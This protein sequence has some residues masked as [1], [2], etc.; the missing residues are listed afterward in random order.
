MLSYVLAALTGLC[1]LGL[2]VQAL[3]AEAGLQFQAELPD[4]AEAGMEYALNRRT[5]Q[6]YRGRGTLVLENHGAVSA[7]VY[8]NGHRVPLGDA[9]TAGGRVRLDVGAWC[10]DGANALKVLRIRPLGARLTVG[11]LYPELIR[12]TPEQAGFSSAGLKKV[13]EVIERDVQKGFPGAVLLVVRNGRIVKETA[14]GWAKLYEGKTL[15]P[16]AQR[17]PMTTATMFDLASETKM[18]AVIFSFMKLVDEGRVSP[19][20]LV[21]QYLPEYQ[22]DGRESVRIRDLMTHSAGYAPVPPLIPAD[23]AFFSRDR[24]KTLSLLMRLPFAYARG[25][26]TVYSDTDYMLLTAVL[27][28]ITGQRLDDY[29]EQAVYQPLGLKHTLFNPLRSGFAVRDFAATEPCGNT[30]S[31]LVDF[32]GIRTKTI[33]GEVQDERAYYTMDGVS[34]H[35]GLFSRA[36]D[37]AVLVQLLLNEGG[38]GSYRLCSQET[39]AYFTK[40]TDRDARFGLGW[41]KMTGPERFWEFGPYAS[42]EA[43]AHSGWTGIDICIDPRYDLGIILLTNRVHA[44]NLPGKPNAFTTDDAATCSYGSIPSLIYEAFLEK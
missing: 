2:P 10:Q 21:S 20:D 24:E 36:E 16:E 14:Y 8:V 38:Y 15:L 41:N 35:A 18:Y 40:P 30:R 7:E 5:F 28:R 11:A 27:E 3:A 6:A 39:L 17:Q 4:A 22:G 42:R 19:E 34:G 44:L 12:G 29:V 23:S 33:Q 31:G 25:T 43:I 9:L 13:D 1:L 37:L 32:P 26:K